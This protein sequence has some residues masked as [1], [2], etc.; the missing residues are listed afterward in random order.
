MRLKKI[1]SQLDVKAYEDLERQLTKTKADHF[2]YLS[3]SYRNGNVNDE[4][5]I[6]HLNINANSFYVLKSRLYTKVKNHLSED[7][8]VYKDDILN[9]MQQI[10]DACYNQPREIAI[11]FLEKLEADLLKYDM[12]SELLV[13]YSALKKVN[14]KSEHYFHYSQLYNKHV[15]F[16]L[17]LEKSEAILGNFNQILAEHEFSKSKLIL[18]KLAFLRLEILNHL[19]LNPSRQI[20]IIK[21]LIDIELFLFCC[22][23]MAPE[24]DI[25]KTLHDTAKK[26]SELPD[27]SSHKKWEIGIDYLFFEYY[28]TLSPVKAQPYY[29]KLNAQIHNLLLYNSICLTPKFLI[30]KIQFLA[31]R[32]EI[33]KLINEST[34]TIL[35]DSYDM[36]SKVM[37]GLYKGMINY[38]GGKTK[39]AITGLNELINEFSFKD[40]F[41]INIEIKL[42]LC[43]LYIQIKDFDLAENIM[44]R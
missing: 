35:I 4:E 6:K 20:E 42:T 34:G 13:V 15:A 27:S 17:S 10:H 43:F 28:K 29:E 7:I 11:A 44:S 38:Y 31:E 18:D 26:I 25:E 23:D 14:L 9:N 3:Q 1:I 12:H 8:D 36:Y 37:L 21:N 30:S 22:K 41:H 33:E 5:I 32:N 40:L 16:W 24:F 2:L 39:A 19:N